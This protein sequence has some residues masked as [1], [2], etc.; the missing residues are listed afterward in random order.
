MGKHIKLSP[1]KLIKQTWRDATWDKGV[2]SIVEIV[3]STTNDDK[4]RLDLVQEGIPEHDK[5]R[6][7]YGWDANFFNRIKNLFGYGSISASF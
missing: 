4:T 3:L 5:N 1:G 7:A 2:V 6:I